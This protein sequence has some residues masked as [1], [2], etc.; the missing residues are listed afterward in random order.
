MPRIFPPTTSPAPSVPLYNPSRAANFM[1][2]TFAMVRVELSRCPPDKPMRLIQ[3]CW[4]Q[5]YFFVPVADRA[6]S[7]E[8][9]KKHQ[10]QKRM[11]VQIPMML[12]ATICQLQPVKTEFPKSFCI[13]LRAV[14]GL[15]AM[16]TGFCI[17]PLATKIH[18]AERLA[19]MAV[20]HVAIR[21]VF[22]PTLFQPKNITAIKVD[23]MKNARIP[24][25]ASG[26]PKISPTNQ[27]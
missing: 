16:P 23:S 3:K 18:K 2:C 4:Q 21:C 20:S 19:P 12:H 9:K 27:E 5:E 13:S 17:Q 6:F 22:L 8:T 10:P 15:K 7:E 11:P 26:A 25:M 24:S 14:S 1:G